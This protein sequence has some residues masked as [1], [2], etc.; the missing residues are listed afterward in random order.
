MGAHRQSAGAACQNYRPVRTRNARL[1]ARFATASLPDH[2]ADAA[3][4]E[5][6]RC[7]RTFFGRIVNRGEKI[8]AKNKIPHEVRLLDCDLM[9][10]RFVLPDY[11]VRSRE[12]GEHPSCSRAVHVT[13]GG[14]NRPPRDF[15]ASTCCEFGKLRRVGKA[16]GA[17]I[18]ATRWLCPPYILSLTPPAPCRGIHR[19]RCAACRTGCRVRGRWPAPRR[20]L[21]RLRPRP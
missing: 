4:P 12:K 13:A 10:K 5:V 19:P 15:H 9:W 16:T 14:R 20:P 17:R 6:R 18:R 11:P 21:C 7:S 1:D 3:L 2:H 8:S